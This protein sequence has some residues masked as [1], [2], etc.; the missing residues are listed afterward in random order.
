MLNH[1]SPMSASHVSILHDGPLLTN[2]TAYRS[3]ATPLQYLSLTRLIVVFLT[4]KLS[5]FMHQPTIGHWLAVKWLIQYLHSSILIVFIKKNSP[6]SLY[7]FSILIGST[8]LTIIRLQV[9][10][11]SF[12]MPVLS[13]GAQRKSPPPKSNIGQLHLLLQRLLGYNFSFKKLVSLL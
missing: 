5:Q 10:I 4:N 8:M 12:L 11:S 2:A 6:L 1:L 13:R 9:S 3:I 7:D